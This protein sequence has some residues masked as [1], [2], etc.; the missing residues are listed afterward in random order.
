MNLIMNAAKAIA[1]ENA[2]RAGVSGDQLQ[3]Y[4]DAW[5]D[6]EGEAVSALKSLKLAAQNQ[7]VIASLKHH[8]TGARQNPD[9]DREIAVAILVDIADISTH[10]RF[11]GGALN[12]IVATAILGSDPVNSWTD[13]VVDAQ[14][15]LCSLQLADEGTLDAIADLVVESRELGAT[16]D[17]DVIARILTVLSGE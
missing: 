4:I 14:G 10:N 16:H 2:I 3:A 9:F 5:E 13:F 1:Y 11:G 17:D 12:R 6:Y 7:E 15:V 8:L